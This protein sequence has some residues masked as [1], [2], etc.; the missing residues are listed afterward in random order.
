MTGRGSS[1]TEKTGV[2]DTD[3]GW[4]GVE[5]SPKATLEVFIA[6]GSRNCRDFRGEVEKRGLIWT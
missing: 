1:D 3:D 2:E 5:N 6:K 4:G